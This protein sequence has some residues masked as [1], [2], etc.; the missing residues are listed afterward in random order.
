[1][2]GLQ[3]SLLARNGETEALSNVEW[4]FWPFFGG[5]ANSHPGR[6]PQTMLYHQQE[7]VQICSFPVL[8]E[9]NVPLVKGTKTVYFQTS[10]KYIYK[11]PIQEKFGP[12]IVCDGLI[13]NQIQALDVLLKVLTTAC[14]VLF[15]GVRRVV[16]DVL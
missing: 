16:H 2:L 6:L 5:K 10:K 4:H 9:G 1:M 15:R 7:N 8:L 12:L 3:F 14:F 11:N 13:K